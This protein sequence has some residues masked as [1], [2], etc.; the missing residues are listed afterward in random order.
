VTIQLSSQDINNDMFLIYS[1][2]YL[3]H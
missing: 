2:E 1:D 3:C